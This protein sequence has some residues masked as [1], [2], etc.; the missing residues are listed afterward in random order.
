MAAPGVD[1]WS[2]YI[3]AAGY[4]AMTGTSVAVPH[5]TGTAALLVA[6]YVPTVLMLGT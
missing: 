6:Q 2:T 3:G 1:V 4:T 5:V